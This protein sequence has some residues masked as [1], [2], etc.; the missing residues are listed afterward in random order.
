MLCRIIACWWHCTCL[1]W[2]HAGMPRRWRAWCVW[3]IMLVTMAAESSITLTSGPLP[4]DQQPYDFELASTAYFLSH[5]RI[6]LWMNE[7]CILTTFDER[8]D[9]TH[10]R[11]TTT[12]CNAA[13]E[14][15]EQYP[16]YD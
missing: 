13:G 1:S 14:S 4:E 11:H 8:K 5:L 12:G 15:T 7:G 10:S 3:W 16:R 6:Q 2:T 9:T